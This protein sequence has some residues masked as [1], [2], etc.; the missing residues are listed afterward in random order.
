M[1]SSLIDQIS[2]FLYSNNYGKYTSMIDVPT[3]ESLRKITIKGY[4]IKYPYWI[5]NYN[6]NKPIKFK[7]LKFINYFLRKYKVI[8]MDI[9]FHVDEIGTCYIYRPMTDSNK[10]KDDIEKFDIEMRERYETIFVPRYV[11]EK[12]KERILEKEKNVSGYNNNTSN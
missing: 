3:Y 5:Q 4:D 9:V 2:P 11:Q 8:Y 6:W 7:I 1:A 12:Q 10:I